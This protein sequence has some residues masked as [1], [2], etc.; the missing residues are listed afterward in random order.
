MEMNLSEIEIGN[1]SLV[2]IITPSYNA[3][4]FI[5]ETI[6]SVQSQTYTNWEMIIIDDVSKDNTCELIK[7]EIKKDNRIRLIE[8]QENR[9]AAIARNTGI[10]NARGKYVAF[11]DSDD[12]WLPEKLEK[13]LTF[14]QN[15]DVAFS[16][17][18]YQI[19]NQDGTLT[20]KIVHVPEKIN[21][22]GL[23]KNTIIGCLTVMLD[24]EKLGKVQMPNIRTRQDTATWLKIL[25]KGHY[26]YGLDEVL[27]KYRKV[28]NSISSKK[29]KMAKMNWKL[30]REIEGLSILKSAWCFINYA[31]NGVVKH[32]VK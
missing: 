30:Y 22:N 29:F 23:L 9:G 13:Q 3:S 12:L 11:L 21:Y 2:S 6:Q 28:E 24:I 4:S 20:D 31:L 1:Q 7:E 10:N 26:A 18:G 19:M 32:F 16:F 25:R 5:K 27:S 15:N 14:M 8:L 17:T